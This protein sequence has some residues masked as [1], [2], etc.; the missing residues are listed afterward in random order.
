MERLK[1]IIEN[2]LKDLEVNERNLFRITS[3][4][5][6]DKLINNVEKR[7]NNFEKNILETIGQDNEDIHIESLMIPKKDLY[8]YE[9]NYEPILAE[10][11]EEINIKEVL[12]KKEEK[13]LKK[14]FINMD[15]RSLENI[16]GTILNGKIV[17]SNIEYPIKLKLERDSKYLEKMKKLYDVSSLNN[18]KWKTYNIPYL[19]KIFKLTAEEYDPE[20]I[21]N[22]TGEEH[23]VI[24]NNDLKGYW[25]EDHI[26]LWN[27]KE[28]ATMSDGL[29]KPTVNKIHFEH[30]VVFDDV[31][32]IYLC[33]DEEVDI[34]LVAK[35]KENTIKIVTNEVRQVKWKFWTIS[36]LE[37]KNYSKLEYPPFD[38]KIN[39]HF[40]NQLK[41]ENDIRLRNKNEI[42]R[43]LNSYK[44]VK[45]YFKFLDVIISENNI[46]HEET[47]EINEFIIDEFKL[48]GRNTRMYFLFEPLIKDSFTDDIL[49]FIIS[50][51]QLYFP[52]Y[53]CRGVLNER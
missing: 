14:V 30:T 15:K 17:G 41:L 19:R 5:T 11:K 33:P 21:E 4:M 46:E 27:I 8:L 12:S 39:D 36:Y 35:T 37:D 48:K 38:N 44:D 45:R 26:I 52:E 25:I 22:L 20:M 23:L 47:Y 16:N 51:M 28:E 29:I 42:R 6:F 32:R 49:S 31:R 18:I 1:K 53:E 50:D 13:I 3:L 43:I 40:I 7:M 2:E 24:N 9:V 34:Y 10:D